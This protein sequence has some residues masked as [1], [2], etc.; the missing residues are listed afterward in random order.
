MGRGHEESHI[1]SLALNYASQL[2]DQLMAD[3]PALRT[4]F[5]LNDVKK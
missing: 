2:S 3:G 1:H 5:A 4:S